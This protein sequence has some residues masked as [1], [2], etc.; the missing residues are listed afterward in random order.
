MR[1]Q[2]SRNAGIID[3]QIDIPVT[4]P[5]CV[6]DG[7]EALATCHVA[8]ERNQIA[9]FLRHSSTQWTDVMERRKKL[10]QSLRIRRD[11]YIIFGDGFLKHV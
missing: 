5:D 11:A 3:E 7:E 4:G 9:M 1:I 2:V 6:G 8:L 10:W